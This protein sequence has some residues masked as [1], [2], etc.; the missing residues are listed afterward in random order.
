MAVSSRMLITLSG[1]DTYFLIALTLAQ[2]ACISGVLQRQ[3]ELWLTAC[4]VEEE[5][6]SQKLAL[7]HSNSACTRDLNCTMD[8]CQH[9]D[10]LMYCVYH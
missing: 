2:K 5:L 9:H 1:N 6:L 10:I 8:R 3:Y 4:M 7:K